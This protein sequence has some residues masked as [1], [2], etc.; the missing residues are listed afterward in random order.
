MQSIIRATSAAGRGQLS[1]AKQVAVPL[2]NEANMSEPTT[3]DHGSAPKSKNVQ[4]PIITT[5]SQK[6]TFYS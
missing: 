1:K 6:V 3:P 4:Y 5:N 2:G